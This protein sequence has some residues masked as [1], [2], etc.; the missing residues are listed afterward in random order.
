MVNNEFI[1]I[2][3][4]TKALYETVIKYEINN[5]C[6]HNKVVVFLEFENQDIIDSKNLIII[7]NYI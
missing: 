2:F 6:Q 4:G 5:L 3:S 1:Y 7:P